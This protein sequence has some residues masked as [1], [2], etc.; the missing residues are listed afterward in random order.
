LLEQ[1]LTHTLQHK[2]LCKLLGLDYVI[3]YKKG[4][5][6]KDADALSRRSHD[7]NV[8]EVVLVIEMIPTWLEE[9]RGSYIGDTWATRVLQ[10][11]EEGKEVDTD[12][13]VHSV[14]LEKKA[15]SMW[16]TIW[17]GGVK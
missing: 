3:Q 11:V 9:L 10:E 4:I 16:A 14:S 15:E 6:N 13:K 12:V 17:I 7:K 5:R 1:W 8:M 2:G